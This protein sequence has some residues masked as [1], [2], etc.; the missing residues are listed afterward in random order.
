MNGWK[1]ISIIFILALTFFSFKAGDIGLQFTGDENF[2]Y[3]SSSRMLSEGDW[4]TPQ[5]YGE[6]RFQK[7]FLF[8]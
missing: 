7:P 5:Y 3:Q 4:I 8:Y 2:Y 6:K 1:T